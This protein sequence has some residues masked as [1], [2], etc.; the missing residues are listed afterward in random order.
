MKKT[1]GKW[2]EESMKS[3]RASAGGGV[4]GVRSKKGKT[5]GFGSRFAYWLV[6]LLQIKFNVKEERIGK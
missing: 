2:N 3:E 4:G 6:D 1:N 5:N